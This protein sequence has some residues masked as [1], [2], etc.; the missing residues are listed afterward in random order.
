MTPGLRPVAEGGLLFGREVLDP[1]RPHRGAGGVV[2]RAEHPGDVPEGRTLDPPLAERP[3]GFA[4]EVDDDE[5]APRPEDLAE[6][7]VAVDPDPLPAD[8][9][10]G[11]DRVA[12]EELVL[13]R[14]QLFD[15]G[16]DLVDAQ[17]AERGHGLRPHRLVQRALVHAGDRLGPEHRIVGAGTER[18][19]ELR[20]AAT[21]EPGRPEEWSDQVVGQQR[22]EL[23]DHVHHGALHARDRL[24][25]RLGQRPLEG[26]LDRVERV[27]PRVALVLHVPLEDRD[28]RSAAT[29]GE[30]DRPGGRRGMPEDGTVGQEPADLEL[31]VD[32]LLEAAEQLQDQPVAE[33]HRGVALI[34]PAELRLERALATE[35]RESF[36]A[37]PDETAALAARHAP[38]LDHL[39]ERDGQRRVPEPVH[40]QPRPVGGLDP[41]HHELGSDVV[42]LPLRRRAGGRTWRVRPR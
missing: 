25:G 9:V 41:R 3:R 15:L 13:A 12:G 16:P 40:Q 30:L 22:R 5:V 26:L 20:R 17:A 28:R 36:G 37:R 6:V 42:A 18:E 8:P 34:A 33:G 32:A 35:P 10:A 38:T 11:Q 4:L 21:E 2:E 39:E 31:R 1:R 29:V 19:V 7:V 23:A 27:R 24:I 14:E